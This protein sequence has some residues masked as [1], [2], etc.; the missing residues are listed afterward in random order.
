MVAE[1]QDCVPRVAAQDDRYTT[2]G[3]ASTYW[4]QFGGKSLKYKIVNDS[5]SNE[6]DFHGVILECFGRRHPPISLQAQ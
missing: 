3:E 4:D 5:N 2:A 1:G 6:M